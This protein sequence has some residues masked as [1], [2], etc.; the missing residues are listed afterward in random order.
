MGYLRHAASGAIGMSAILAGC[1]GPQECPIF[2]AEG[3]G[4]AITIG[5][6]ECILVRLD[7]NATTGYAWQLAEMDTVVLENTDQEYVQDF[8]PPGMA[9]VGGTE[10]WEFAGKVPGRTN[11]RLEYRRPWEPE[12]IEP[13]DTF[14]IDVTVTA[15]E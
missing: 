9:G 1:V 15:A 6:A 8:A 7:S 4:R 11:L 14:E 12:D 2:T 10:T 5:V 3:N 13:A